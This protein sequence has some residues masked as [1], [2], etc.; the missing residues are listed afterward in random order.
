MYK[1]FSHPIVSTLHSSV[2]LSSHQDVLE[3]AIAG[4]KDEQWEARIGRV[5]IASPPRVV[6]L[7]QHSAHK[8]SLSLLVT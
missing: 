1:E 4:A 7:L 2:R 5:L 3:F 8:P 6:R